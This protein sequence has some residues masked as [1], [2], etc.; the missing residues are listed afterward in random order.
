MSSALE[1]TTRTTPQA[2]VLV[3]RGDVGADGDAPI[4]DAYRAAVEGGSTSVV[5]NLAETQYIN[6][7]GISVLI[8]IVM[9]AKQQGVAVAVAGASPHYRKVFDLVRFSSFVSMYD[10]EA[11]ALAGFGSDG[12]PAD[13]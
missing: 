5:F 9:E 2:A 3:L 8:A 11:E 13:Q 7:S 6:T 10:D 4:K 1:I 12:H